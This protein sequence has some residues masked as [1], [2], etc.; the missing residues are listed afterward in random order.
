MATVT[1]SV[2]GVTTPTITYA[3]KTGSAL[4]GEEAINAGDYT[5]SIKLGEA[6]A[7]LPFTIDKAPLTITADAQT[8]VYGE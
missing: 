7:T 1:G 2:E 8:K 3:A 6:T 5:A 4:T